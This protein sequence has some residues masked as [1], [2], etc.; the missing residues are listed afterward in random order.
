MEVIVQHF[1]SIVFDINAYQL[2]SKH[3]KD[4]QQ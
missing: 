3:E 4:D 2:A 1:D